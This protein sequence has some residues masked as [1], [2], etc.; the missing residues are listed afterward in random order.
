MAVPALVENRTACPAC[1]Q[2]IHPIAG[3]C[4]H[5]KVDLT[6]RRGASS[7]PRPR[8]V[9]LGS[10]GPVPAAVGPTGSGPAGSAPHPSGLPMAAPGPVYVDTTTT[11]STRGPAPGSWAG[12]WPIVVAVI[13]VLA[14]LI[15]LAFLV[16]D[17]GGA[18]QKK[19]LAALGPAPER[20][21]TEPMTPRDPPAA[22]GK[23]APTD[24][25]G[26]TPPPPPPAPDPAAPLGVPPTPPAPSGSARDFNGF[27]E[28]AIDEGC[29]RLSSCTGGDPLIAA[30]CSLARTSLGQMQSS[31]GSMCSEFDPAA[32]ARCLA[33]IAAFPCPAGGPVDPSQMAVTLMGLQGCSALCGA[34]GLGDD[35]SADPLAP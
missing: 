11:M 8:L 10:D 16:F 31:F 21:S 25:G 26:A 14:I 24:P 28:S 6:G 3:R 33:S 32:A 35:P 1:G 22:P 12:R 13:A 9:A 34:G 30:Q 19:R 20:M 18:K 23:T 2:P 17:L 4:K 7:A 29:K 5:C 15:S 27:V